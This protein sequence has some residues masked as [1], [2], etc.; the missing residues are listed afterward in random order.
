MRT[1]NNASTGSAFLIM[2]LSLFFSPVLLAHTELIASLPADK[3]ALPQSPE[4][5]QLSFSDPVRLMRL[6]LRDEQGDRIAL[7]YRPK[8]KPATEH[9]HVLPQALTSGVYN[10]E[11]SVMASDGHS[12]SGEISFAVVP[13]P[14]ADKSKEPSEPQ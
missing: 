13:A 1:I 5:L 14:S 7:N 4:T 6:T 2:L 10:L 9:R 12:M 11:W 8:T 3:Q